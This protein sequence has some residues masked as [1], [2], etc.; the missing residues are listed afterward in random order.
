M[1]ADPADQQRLLTLAE[2]DSEVGRLQHTARNLPQHA[3]IA[4][5]MRA[6]Q[7]VTDDL[8]AATTRAG[9]LEV[10]VRRA[11]ADLMPVRSRLERESR[12]VEDG[13]IADPKVLRGLT[14]EVDRIRRRIGELEDA[15]LE[16]MGQ[17]EDA[18]AERDRLTARKAEVEQQLRADVAERDAEVGKLS[19]EAKAISGSRAAEAKKLPAPL[20]DL[21][22][23]LRAHSGLGAAKLHR[24]RCTGCQLEA[25]VSDLDGYRKTPANEVLRCVECDRI[26]VRTAD[27]GL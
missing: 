25:T 15:Q 27:S 10:S 3:R 5:L 21:Y 7:A 26:L 18:A 19:A 2:L 1:L 9:D 14:E 11:E 23:K 4:E 24:G 16:L 17:L 13:S 12:R 6:R 8:V 20:L 22:E